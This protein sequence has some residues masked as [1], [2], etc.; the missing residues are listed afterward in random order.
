M[1]RPETLASKTVSERRSFRA[2]FTYAHAIC[3][4]PWPEV[5][6][7]IHH[8]VR[9]RPIES[10]H[11][12][13]TS[14]H[15]HWFHGPTRVTAGEKALVQSPWPCT[16]LRTTGISKGSSVAQSCSPADPFPWGTSRTGRNIMILWLKRPVVAIRQTRSRVFARHHI[17]HS[18]R[19]WTR[20]RTSSHIR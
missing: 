3:R 17:P 20:L 19:R 11:V 1:R 9:W 13:K 12:S 16:C 7:D 4:T 14:S 6:T 8:R 5:G 2:R 15:I 18:R 10:D